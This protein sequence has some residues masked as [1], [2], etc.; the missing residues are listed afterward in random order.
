[1]IRTPKR[2]NDY[3]RASECSGSPLPFR[4]LLAAIS[5]NAVTISRLSV[6]INGRPPANSCLARLDASMTSSKRFET[7]SRQSSTVIRATFNLP[8][9]PLFLRRK[10]TIGAKTLKWTTPAGESCR[11]QIGSPDSLRREADYSARQHGVPDLLLRLV[12]CI[13]AKFVLTAL[14]GWFQKWLDRRFIR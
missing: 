5:L 14:R 11:R 1:L 7:F 3:D 9:D 2:N 4:T 6:S 13:V 8:I 12:C 10:L